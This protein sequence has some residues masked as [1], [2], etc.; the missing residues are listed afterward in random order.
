MPELDKY[1]FNVG[2]G[3]SGTHAAEI[4]KAKKEL[5]NYMRINERDGEHALVA[6]GL[7]TMSTPTITAPKIPARIPDAPRRS[8]TNGR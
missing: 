6:H 1:S 2:V 4:E 7:D 8:C 5:E 3:N